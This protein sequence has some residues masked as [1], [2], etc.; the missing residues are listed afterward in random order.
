M[1]RRKPPKHPKRG[2]AILAVLSVLVLMAVLVMSIFTMSSVEQISSKGERDMLDSRSLANTTINLV[3]AQLREATEQRIGKIPAPWASQPGAVNVQRLDG[4]T[5]TIF[6]L[7]SAGK[8]TAENRQDL[9]ADIPSNWNRLPEQ[10]VDLNAPVMGKELH[11]PIVDPR[12]LT[13]DLST[14]SPRS[15]E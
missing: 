10:Y 6:K 9:L 4:T 7:Y 14:S 8:L 5:D 15:E 13:A 3:I 11:F 1:K 2:V 12:S